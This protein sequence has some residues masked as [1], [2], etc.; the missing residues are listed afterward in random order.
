MG[1]KEGILGNNST[2][3]GNGSGEATGRLGTDL[4]TPDSEVRRIS[5]GSAF[6]CVWIKLEA[7][8]HV[9][10]LETDVANCELLTV[11]EDD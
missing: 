2:R 11:L 6:S 4:G 9:L 7:G 5:V 1:S 3:D 8:F 10:N